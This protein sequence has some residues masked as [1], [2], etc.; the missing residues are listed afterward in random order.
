MADSLMI[1]EVFHSIQGES[2]H[3]GRPCT[4]IRLTG[5]HLRCTWCDTEY[6]FLE[7]RRM[8]ID[9]L[10]EQARSIGCPLVEVTGGEPLLQTGCLK[11]LTRLADAGFEVLL[12]TSGACDIAAVDPRVGRIVDVK[13]PGSGE[14]DRNL[15]SNL[16]LLKNG[17]EVKFIVA[18]R[19][20]YDFARDVITRHDLAARVPV[21]VSPVFGQLDP[22]ELATWILA[23]ALPVRLQ[24]QLHKLIW[25]PDRRGV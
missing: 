2:T 19:A 8:A 24:L 6:A 5:C 25:S 12:E 9:E 14:A 16:N 1:N 7:G 10:V 3:V 18:D 21:L 20:D 11:L 17:D 23:D 13:C 22:A 15:W 4:F